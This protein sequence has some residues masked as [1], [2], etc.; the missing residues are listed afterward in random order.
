MPLPPG[1]A[2]VTM[3][4][5]PLGTDGVRTTPNRSLTR[6]ENIW[7]LRSGLNVAALNCQG[8]VW[9]EIAQNYNR[10]LQVHKSRLAQSNKSVDSEYVKRFP[11]QNGL[12]VR[13]TRMTDLYNYFALPPVRAEFCDK[14]LAKSREIVNLPSTALPEYSFGALA[15]LDAVFI[16]FF[17]AFEQYKVDIVEWN[18]RYG[19]QPVAQAYAPVSVSS[20]TTK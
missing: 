7:H 14:S 12:R 19:P 1:G 2:A 9:G 11:G 8:P 15:D 20:A 5:P 17:N 18:A 4:V 10:F 3:K 13:D 16:N 6:E